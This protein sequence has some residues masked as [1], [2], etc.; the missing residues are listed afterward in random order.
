M[1]QSDEQNTGVRAVLA[2]PD[3]RRL[4]LGQTISQIGDG[5]TNLAILIVINKLSGSTAAL[6][7]MMIVI[8]L[9]QLVFGLISGVFVDRWDRKKIMIISDLIRGGLVMGF[10]LVRRPEDIWIFYVLGFLQAAIGTLFDPAK[11]AI[12]PNIVDRSMLLAANSLSQTTRVITGVIGSALAGVLVGL[13]GTASPAFLL[14]GLSFFLSALFISRIANPSPVEL[15]A[16]G[17]VRETLGQLSD[18]LH[19]M[20]SRRLLVGVMVTFAV[21]MLGL[22][23]INVLIVPFLVNHLQI[24][25]EALGVTEAAQVIGMVVGSG[26]VAILAARLK[27]TQIIVAGI[28]GLGL[29][30]AMFGA[31]NSVWMA[32]VILFLVGLCLTPAQSAASTII[33][34]NVPDDKRGRAGSALNTVITLASVI[35]MASAGLLGDALGVREVFFL[36][37]GV[38]ACAGLLAAVL[39]RSPGTPFLP[40]AGYLLHTLAKKPAD[41]QA[42]STIVREESRE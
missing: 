2:I 21:T 22:G 39:M 1:T 5:L 9:P 29:C 4:W 16:T 17:G 40:G 10:I 23:A 11:S 6:A 19:F 36:S 15:L 32:L 30:V 34:A 3:F 12:I 25:T 31:V 41:E 42:A 26:L 28:F 8:A 18:G 33:Q 27:V 38:T 14:D 13:A 7:T 37:G 20:A 35:S 24:S